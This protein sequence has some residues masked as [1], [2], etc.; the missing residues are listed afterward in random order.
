MRASHIATNAPVAGHDKPP[1]IRPAAVA[2]AEAK[3]EPVT[4]ATRS[5]GASPAPGFIVRVVFLSRRSVVYESGQ[6]LD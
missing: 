4:M 5:C 2:A 1:R 6:V 3:A